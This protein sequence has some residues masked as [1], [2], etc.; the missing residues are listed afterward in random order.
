MRAHARQPI[1]PYNV[2]DQLTSATGSAGETTYGYD[3]RGNLTGVTTAGGTTS[4]AYDAAD[5][6][7]Q[8][9][10][11]GTGISGAV[12][13]TYGYDADGRRV[14]QSDGTS[15]TTFLWD[16]LSPNGDV[17]L[18]TDG[19]GAIQ[20][21]YTLAG[22]DVLAQ[23][24]NGATQY[25]LPDGQGSV[26]G[27]ADSSGL[28]TDRYRYDAYGTLRSHT[29]GITTPTY[30]YTGQR[31]DAANGLYDLRARYYDPST[32]RFL[33]R[34]TLPQGIGDTEEFNRYVYTHDD[35]IDFSDPSGQ[36]SVAVPLPAAG[37]KP[38]GIGG[39]LGEYASL[40][41]N[42][43]II[44]VAVVGFGRATDCLSKYVVSFLMALNHNGLGLLALDAQGQSKPPRCHIPVF[45]F[46]YLV[47]PHIGQHIE[48][49]QNGFPGDPRDPLYF[50]GG[51][52]QPM[53]LSYVGKDNP[54]KRSNYLA[55]CTD[56]R[57]AQ[58]R[59]YPDP[60]NEHLTSCDEYAFESS[61]Q[62]GVL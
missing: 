10:P 1:V 29:D 15:T 3:G 8:V 38:A 21:S 33:G 27:L 62:G 28:V 30:A 55:A 9:T 56:A 43:L 6:L 36:A 23:A 17:V 44:A 54:Q 57:R 13:T 5:R 34:D 50:K 60:N 31:F 59:G 22:S 2:L 42:A 7:M 48:A 24:H 19:A 20:A 46:P 58:L 39:T 40:L 52:A 26:R 12:P 47:M 4:Y 41:L 18:E 49:A 53:L 35:P 11:A 32:G 61:L 45:K 16:E 51:P 14:R 25:L 37:T